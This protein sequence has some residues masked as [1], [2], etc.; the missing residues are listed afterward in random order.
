MSYKDVGSRRLNL[1]AALGSTL[2]AMPGLWLGAAGALLVC[3][4]GWLVP[5]FRTLPG[6]ME[7]VWG[8]A[9]GLATLVAVGGL[10][11]LSV[12]EDVRAARGLGLGP[13][14]LQFGWPEARLVVSALFCLIFL[15]M[16]V[17][18][19][20]LAVLALLGAAGLDLA[21]FQAGDRDRVGAPW[22]LGL[23][24]V[25]GAAALLIPLL[26]VVRLS[27][28]VPATLGRNQMVSLNSMGIAYGSY[29][30][31]L[32][33]LIIT[34]LPMAGLLAGVRTAGLAAPLSPVILV[35]GLVW[36]QLPLTLALLGRAY[37]QLEYWT[38]GKAAP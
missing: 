37:R 36:L 20:A 17:I 26:F 31:L 22:K 23:L 7:P 34:A 19:L 6:W 29:W 35:V 21:A 28:F 2:R 1:Q 25:P 10:A 16:I 32:A 15:A 18:V 27:L 5:V 4:A 24:A 3:T 38:P 12:T 13:A 30:P 33:G 11:R 8:I 14:G 9:A